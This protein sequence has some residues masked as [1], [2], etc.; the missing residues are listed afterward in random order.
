MAKTTL[1]SLPQGER[2]TGLYREQT[3]A[4]NDSRISGIVQDM[5]DGLRNQADGNRV[6]LK[7]AERVK[8]ACIDYVQACAD[9][10]TLPSMRGLASALGCSRQNLW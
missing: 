9:N 5:A 10:S 7:D 4:F 6:S 2:K 8:L 1:D 3:A